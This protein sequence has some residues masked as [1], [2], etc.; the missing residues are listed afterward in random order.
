MY[1]RPVEVGPSPQAVARG[2]GGGKP[3]SQNAALQ[4]IMSAVQ[5]ATA[6]TKQAV[7]AALS[8]KGSSVDTQA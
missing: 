2:G 8:G 4:L 7:A 6:S 3:D 1:V 5:V